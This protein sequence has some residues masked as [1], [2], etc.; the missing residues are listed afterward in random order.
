MRAASKKTIIRSKVAAV[1]LFSTS[2]LP[3]GRQPLSVTIVGSGPSAFY[4]AKHISLLLAPGSKKNP[5]PPSSLT[6]NIVEKNPVPFGLVRS[7]VAPDHEEVKNVV[8]DF[9]RFWEEFSG[10]NGNEGVVW[11]F[12][13]GVEVG[14]DVTLEDVQSAS[15]C[16]VLAYGCSSDTPL[17]FG[18][19]T[20]VKDLDLRSADFPP[21]SGYLNVLPARKFVHWYNGY[22]FGKE[23]Q[24]QQWRL[25]QHK[26]RNVVV[27]GNGNVAID[28]GRVIVKGRVS[29][30]DRQVEGESLFGTDLSTRAWELLSA[31]DDVWR[32]LE[33]V[34]IVGRR[35]HLQSSFTIKELRELTR[36]TGDEHLPIEFDVCAGEI[37]RGRGFQVGKEALKERPKKRI[38]KVFS[39]FIEVKAES[40]SEGKEGVKLALKFFLAPH[41]IVVDDADD[42]VVTGVTFEKTTLDDESARAVG[43]N[44][45][46]FGSLNP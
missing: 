3:P 14:N 26:I 7:G 30:A 2:G 4:S 28:C 24:E 6:I 32:G 43:L 46:S 19:G 33:T 40:P 37:E 42:S 34:T 16:T 17:T 25:N 12:F 1:R 10:D 36:L 9:T 23:R 44:E 35:S 20:I 29:S 45:V 18:D 27:I 38:D 41:S 31:D 5:C 22:T 21:Q 11:N 8:N 15:D 13:G 39:D